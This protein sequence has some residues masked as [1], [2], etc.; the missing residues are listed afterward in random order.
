MT[1]WLA[2]IV[3]QGAYILMRAKMAADSPLPNHVSSIKQ[4]FVRSWIAFLIR[5][6]LGAGIFSL[7]MAGP[8]E[9]A[10]HHIPQLPR[11]IPV[12]CMFGLCFDVAFDAAQTKWPWLKLKFTPIKD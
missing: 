11:L 5:W 6:I 2:F 9:I 3:G 1:L 7:A 8:W 10:G 4:Y 12:A